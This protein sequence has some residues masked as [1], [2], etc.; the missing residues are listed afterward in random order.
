MAATPKTA[1][2]SRTAWRA[3]L[4]RAVSLIRPERRAAG[5]IL[6][7]ASITG[8]LQ[9]MEPLLFGLAVNALASGGESLWLA[10]LWGLASLLIFASSLVLSVLADRLSHR[11][12]VAA[13]EQF[14]EHVLALPAS[15]HSTS[16]SGR[17]MRVMMTGCDTLFTL[18]LNLFREQ[19]TNLVAISLLV[20][21]ALYLNWRLALLLIALLC[22]YVA[23]NLTVIANTAFRQSKVEDQVS[24]FSGHAGDLVGNVTVLQ[25]FLAVSL[26]MQM[27]RHSLGRILANQ[28]PVLNW[29]AASS[30]LTRGA[31]SI[32]VVVIFAFGAHLSARGEASIGEIVAFIGFATLMIARLD[33]A[34]GFA[35][36]LVLRVPLISQF[37]AILDER[38]QIT[39]KCDASSL[40][41]HGGEIAFE[42]VTFRYPAGSGGVQ[43]LTFQVAAGKTTAIVGPTGSGKSTIL[44][45]LTRAYDPEEGRIL[46]DGTDIR[47]VTLSSLRGAIGVVFQDPALFSRT[48]AENIAIGRP[49]ASPAEIE[50]AARDAGALDFILR[51]EN[52][53]ETVLGERGQ[54]LSGGERQ[55]VAIARALLKDAP[56]LILDEATAALDA[57][58]EVRIQEALD[59]LRQGR[60]TLVIAHRL[61]TVRSADNIILLEQGRIAE[62]G[63]F[64]ALLARKGQFAQMVSHYKGL[65]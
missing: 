28:Y 24:S 31:S 40:Q 23:I 57:A 33:Q 15:F 32:A 19:L 51:K 45:L 27:V 9:V 22:I 54:G 5:M 63:T 46:V 49:G 52:G 58:T 64:D 37:F 44:A 7:A 65:S 62:S 38:P 3:T 13:M 60:T 30:V 50:N 29:W 20:P 59:R 61:A 12:R 8:T 14:L 36:A 10:M 53:F 18:W 6:V 56:L 43:N 39:E 42:N 4:W 16:Q 17:L 34:S 2:L 1:Q 35:A 55:R 26:E 21:I 47:D 25:S 41:V 11:R 48:I